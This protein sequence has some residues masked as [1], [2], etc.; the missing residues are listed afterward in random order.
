MEEKNLLWRIKDRIP[1]LFGMLAAIL[2]LVVLNV[3]VMGIV[4]IAG[5]E[6]VWEAYLLQFLGTAAGGLVLLLIAL[7]IGYGKIFREKGRGIL[8]SIGTGGYLLTVDGIAL[9]SNFGMYL[10]T[11]QH[12]LRSVQPALSISIFILSMLGIGFAE[13]LAYRGICMNLLREKIST[14]TDGGIFLVLA[15][16]G[17]FFGMCHM[18]NAFGGARLEG[19]IVQAVMAS[20]LGI[21]LG[22]I[23]LRTNSFWFVAGLHAFNDFCALIPS[24]IYGIDNLTDTISGYSWMNLAGAPVYILVIG[25]LLRRS[26]REEIKS[27]RLMELSVPQKVVKGILLTGLSLFL[28][29]LMFTSTLYVTWTGM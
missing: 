25:I 14:K 2:Y 23:Y 19:V 13:E 22:A 9:A 20:L 27:G 18:V 11:E 3:S 29:F 17:V 8:Y 1:V 26:K 7:G 15:I 16:Q 28:I 5:E 10:L 4:C 24:G 6:M 12:E 21:M